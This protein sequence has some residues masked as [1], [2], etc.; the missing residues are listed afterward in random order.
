MSTN[1]IPT[2]VDVIDVVVEPDE[3]WSEQEK[4]AAAM[5]DGL[6]ELARFVEDNPQFVD[7]MSYP[8]GCM[9]APVNRVSNPRDLIAEFARAAAKRGG[10]VR[11]NFSADWGGIDVAFGPVGVHVYTHRADVCE[12]VVVGTE[13]VVKEVPDPAAPKVTV[14]ETVEKVEWRCTPLLAAAIESGVDGA[15]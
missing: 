2:A 6:R 3:D 5:A 9:N 13:Q 12:R 15:P 8:L 1:P 4:R 14:T 11:K 7:A 10:V